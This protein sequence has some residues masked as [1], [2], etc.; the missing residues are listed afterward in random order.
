[1]GIYFIY[2]K[3]KIFLEESKGFLNSMI[4]NLNPAENSFAI[5]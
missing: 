1:M 3:S 2:V 5:F 4:A